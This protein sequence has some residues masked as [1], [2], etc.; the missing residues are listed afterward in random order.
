[1]VTS[2][3]NS[4]G[5]ADKQNQLVPTECKVTSQTNNVD[6]THYANFGSSKIKFKA[7]LQ[8]LTEV[9]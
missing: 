2:S 4:T 7:R 1:M 6:K 5:V 3:S 8:L 9:N